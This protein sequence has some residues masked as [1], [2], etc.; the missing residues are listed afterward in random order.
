LF[1]IFLYRIRNGLKHQGEIYIIVASSRPDLID[2]ALLRPGRIEKH[3]Y[4]GLPEKSDVAS[5]LIKSI[6][7]KKEITSEITDAINFIT[8]NHKTRFMTAADL[9]GIV[10][11]AYLQAAHERMEENVHSQTTLEGSKPSELKSI[12]LLKAFG[13]TNPS[14]TIED[15]RF[16]NQIYLSFQSTKTSHD[17]HKI[18][19]E[20]TDQRTR[21]DEIINQKVSLM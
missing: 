9:K 7:I 5:I 6:G 13:Q 12:H 8:E 19:P 16:Y 2:G 18:V 21:I 11:T 4:V 15:L 3:I 1:I 10:C 20:L 14:V 17:D